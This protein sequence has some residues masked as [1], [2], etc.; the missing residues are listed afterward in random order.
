MNRRIPALVLAVMCSVS[1]AFGASAEA[2]SVNTNLTAAVTMSRGRQ[3]AEAKR[4]AKKVK[5][6][7]ASQ[8]GTSDNKADTKTSAAATAEIKTGSG[9]I[10]Q[11]TFTK[12]SIPNTAGLNFTKNMKLGWNLGNT[13]DATGSGY[14]NG[15]ITME[16]SWVG[17]KTT[18]KMIDGIKA[19][20][21]NTVRVP[22]SWHNHVSGDDF[23]IDKE[24]MDRVQVS[25]LP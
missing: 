1:M 20:G 10:P 17:I 14:A 23:T 19:S 25:Y 22:V 2:L 7:T 4:N 3:K 21:F 12:Q 13:F 18:K 6:D 24:W 5:T 9:M 15:S 16:S 8:S 11:I